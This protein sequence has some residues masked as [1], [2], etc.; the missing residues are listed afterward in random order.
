VRSSLLDVCAKCG[1]I[2]DA[3]R[4]PEKMPSK[5]VVSWTGMIS[6][7]LNCREGQKALKLF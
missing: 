3:W 2:E 1:S 6:G 7:H 4:V 5:D